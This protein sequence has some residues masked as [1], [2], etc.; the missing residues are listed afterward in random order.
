MEEQQRGKNAS[1]HERAC[2]CPVGQFFSFVERSLG[3]TDEFRKHIYNSKVEFLRAIRSL[4]D[5]KIEDLEARVR[6]PQKQA[7]RIEVE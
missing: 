3:I 5:K 2:E 7:E 4:I 6:T 1:C